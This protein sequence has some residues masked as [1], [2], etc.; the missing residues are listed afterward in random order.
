MAGKMQVVDYV[1]DNGNTYRIRVD[2]SNAA[3]AGLAATTTG[4]DKP[5]SLRPRYILAAHPD[6]GRQ[7]KIIVNPT[8]GLWTGALNTISLPDFDATMAATNYAIMGRIGEK[9]TRRGA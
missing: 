3:A 1:S 8:S 4:I 2:A 7:R 5:G 9:R 6:T